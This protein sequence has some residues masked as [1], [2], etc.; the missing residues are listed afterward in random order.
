MA[1]LFRVVLEENG[2]KRA[3]QISD[4]EE[5]QNCLRT[6]VEGANQGTGRTANSPPLAAE[7]MP[8]EHT[9]AARETSL[10]AQERYGQEPKLAPPGHLEL[11]P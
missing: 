7:L 10:T 3:T 6:I 4:M 5:S 2:G 8:S 11:M 1:D 9:T